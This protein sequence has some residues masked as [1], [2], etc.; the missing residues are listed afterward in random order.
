[1][2]VLQVI[3]TWFLWLIIYSF[4]GWVYESI[5]CSITNKKLINRGFLNGPY[6][7]IYGCGALLILL[8]LGRL[9]N[10]VLLFFA[11]A[12]VTC[13]LEY[14]TSYI[15]EKLFHARWW[16]YS[17]MKFNIN[18]RVC[19]AG[20]VV[21]GAG[22]VALILFLQ[23]AVQRLTDKIPA[24]WLHIISGVL[25]LVFT[26]DI[27][28]TVK[29]FAGFHEK[30]EEICKYV[31]EQLETQKEEVSDKLRDLRDLRTVTYL[32]NLRE[33]AR[34]KLNWQQRR[35]IAAFPAL[36]L[37]K[38]DHNAVLLKLRKVLGTKAEKLEKLAS[39]IKELRNL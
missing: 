38:P 6:C 14:F 19:L 21:F 13:S 18:G 26:S 20:A 2:T 22:A 23:P 11:G 8:I 39:E 1:M 4:V 15:M 33:T 24:L 25:F 3:E 10:P 7:P 9:H 37:K 28:V 27:V 17:Y 12:L 35:M 29:G 31:E 30:L 32:K 36:K 16:D 5:L 34:N